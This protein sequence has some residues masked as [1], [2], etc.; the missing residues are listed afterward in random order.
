MR[1]DDPEFSSRVRI[2]RKLT[3]AE[4]LAIYGITIIDD[5]PEPLTPEEIAK[6]SSMLDEAWMMPAVRS[7]A[8]HNNP[9]YE[10]MG[11]KLSVK[12]IRA[13]K[14]ANRPNVIEPIEGHY[15]RQKTAQDYER[16][17]A[18]LFYSGR[19]WPAPDR[20]HMVIID[21]IAQRCA[22]TMYETSVCPPYRIA[23]FP[24]TI[25]TIWMKAHQEEAWTLERVRRT[26][27]R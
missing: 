3:A 23:G 2:D 7:T 1:D 14:A 15:Q 8:F 10:E 19:Q 24:L 22:R 21:A 20:M 16:N 18:N 11:A 13:M 17:E 4:A 25:S 9:L 26:A 27:G 5:A 12:H 6:Y